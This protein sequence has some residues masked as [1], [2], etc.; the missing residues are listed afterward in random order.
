MEP[1]NDKPRTERALVLKHFEVQE[2]SLNDGGVLKPGVLMRMFIADPA[3]GRLMPSDLLALEAMDAIS[4]AQ[5]ILKNAQQALAKTG[6][7]ARPQA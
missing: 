7:S 1:G 3:T 4:M 2:A 5:L 6:S